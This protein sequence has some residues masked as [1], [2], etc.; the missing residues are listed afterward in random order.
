MTG[1]RSR[2]C[3]DERGFSLIEVTIAMSMLVILMVMSLTMVV[4]VRKVFVTNDDEATGQTDVRTAVER[5]GR[6]IRSARGIDTGAT[7]SRLEIWVDSNSDYR[8]VA[9]EI[10]VWELQ[11]AGGGQF[12][13]LRAENGNATITAETIIDQLAFCYRIDATS[14]C[15]S[16]PLSAADARR[17]RVVE[18]VMRYDSRTTTGSN[19][20]NLVVTERLRNVG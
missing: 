13:V 14:P 5:L 9:S 17:V 1:R 18:S 19:A 11:A 12:N 4:S 20:R 7:A 10:V 6:D 8:R 2:R 15:L 16:T 3:R